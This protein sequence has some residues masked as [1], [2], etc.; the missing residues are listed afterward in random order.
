MTTFV[1]RATA[2]FESDHAAFSAI[3][4]KVEAIVNLLSLAQF[5]EVLGAASDFC[6]EEDE[7][8]TASSA[9]YR[10]LRQAAERLNLTPFDLVCWFTEDWNY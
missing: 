1:A 3:Y 6:Y 7:T 8:T 2:L 4:Q 9:I 10:R 5:R